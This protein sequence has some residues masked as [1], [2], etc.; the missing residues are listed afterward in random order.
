MKGLSEYRGSI[1]SMTAREGILL[2][3]RTV[4]GRKKPG[5]ARS[6]SSSFHFMISRP[7]TQTDDVGGDRDALFLP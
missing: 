2:N 1:R 3:Q 6:H 4:Y 7:D 5:K